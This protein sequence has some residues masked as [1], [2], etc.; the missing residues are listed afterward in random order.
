MT[1]ADAKECKPNSIISGFNFGQELAIITEQSGKLFA[2][3]NKLPP[4]SQPATF[5]ELTNKGTIVEPISLS[6]FSLS[7]GQPIGTWCPSPLGQIIIKRLI[8]PTPCLMFPVRKQGGKVQVLIDV[9]A[10][11]AFEANYWRGVLDAQG[12][13]DGGYY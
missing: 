3:S 6:E 12:K 5:G 8:G 13:V 4:T 1:F 9:N 2:M 10:K 7:T 11:A